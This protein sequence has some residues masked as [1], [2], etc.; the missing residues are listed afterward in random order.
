MSLNYT[1]FPVTENFTLTTPG[2]G[3]LPCVDLKVDAGTVTYAAFMVLVLI[4]A[5]LGNSLVCIAVGL[6]PKLRQDPTTYFIISLAVSDMAFAIFQAPM[7]ISIK[8]N[9]NKFCFDIGACL[10]L[11]LSDLILTPATII[12]LFVIAADRFYCIDKPFLYQEKVTKKKAK[13]VV[14]LVW[15]CACIVASLFL[16]KW[17]DPSQP[18]VKGPGC[19]TDNKYFYSMLNFLVILIPLVIMGIMYS[20]ILRIALS[21]IRAI[22]KTSRLLTVPDEN[23]NRRSSKIS[24]RRAHR[25]LRV[26]ATL[27]M[28]YGAFVICW[29]PMCIVNIIMGIN[30]EVL[31]GPY[32]KVPEIFVI[33]FDCLPMVSTAVNPVIYNF[34]N[35]QFRM[36]FRVAMHRLLGNREILRRATV[37]KELGSYG[38]KE[39]R[40]QRAAT[41]E[42]RHVNGDKDKILPRD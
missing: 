16:F 24:Q 36:A 6:S 35:K 26:T 14:A 28:V 40:F 31:V 3:T 23:E 19:I 34:T 4:V 8:L 15:L 18:S 42:M 1:T 32:R 12:T 37:I 25:E 29:L 17:D 30:K 11:V 13:I 9:N 10:M 33:I 5:L 41:M 38:K 2:N 7:K 27:A 39:A 21:H 22:K 20:I